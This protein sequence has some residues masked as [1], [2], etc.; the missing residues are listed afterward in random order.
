[1]LSHILGG[2]NIDGEGIAGI[3]KSFNKRLLNGKDVTVSIHKG[4]QYITEKIL[5]EQIK[6]F[7][8][9]GGAGIVMNAKNGEIYAITSLPDYNANS[10]NS[11]FNQ[12]LFNRATKGI[13]ELGST[14][15]LITAA[16]AFESGRVNESDVFDVSNPLRI[17]SRTIRDFHPLKLSFKYSR[18][19]CS[20]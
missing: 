8:A 10:Y 19:N 14:L 15:K 9:E 6:K 3:E 11:I 13:Y 2:T 5:S 4:I 18:G 12:N 16:V 7:E 1:M 17:S 20:F